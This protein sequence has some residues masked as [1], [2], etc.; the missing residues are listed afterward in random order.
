MLH[1]TAQRRTGV[2]ASGFDTGRLR[3]VPASTLESCHDGSGCGRWRGA[4][5]A[6]T[7][8]LVDID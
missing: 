5:D 6:A 4:A 3:L 8:V 1:P 7:S 2:G